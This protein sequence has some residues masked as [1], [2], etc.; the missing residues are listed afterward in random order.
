MKVEARAVGL[1]AMRERRGLTQRK[2][3]HD[4]SISQN[5]I[6][7]IEANGRQAGPKLQDQLATYFRCRS[8][9]YLRSCSVTQR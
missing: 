9:I 7:A 3:A 5:Y 8:R 6:P 2:V 4:L 1:E